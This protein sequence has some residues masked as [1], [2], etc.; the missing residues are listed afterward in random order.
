M[1]ITR[2]RYFHPIFHA[3]RD[4]KKYLK[5][6]EHTIVTRSNEEP[7]LTVSIMYLNVG[8]FANESS[9]ISYNNSRAFSLDLQAFFY[10]SFALQNPAACKPWCLSTYTLITLDLKACVSRPP[11]QKTLLPNDD[12]FACI[13]QHKY[14]HN[15][16]YKHQSQGQISYTNVTNTI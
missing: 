12:F 3:L 8:R 9:S 14:D 5:L 2:K 16:T 1:I 11:P 15:W 4:I 13:V 10:N 7:G 6:Q